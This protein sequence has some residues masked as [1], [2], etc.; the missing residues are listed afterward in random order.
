MHVLNPNLTLHLVHP[1][2]TSENGSSVLGRLVRKPI[3]SPL[4]GL[5]SAHIFASPQYCVDMIVEV[6]D[7]TPA[8]IGFCPGLIV[9]THRTTGNTLRFHCEECSLMKRIN[10]S[11]NGCELH[12]VERVNYM[13]FR[14]C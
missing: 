13:K 6:E 9:W 1:K 7:S 5:D 11:V 10:I 14:Q 2:G 3:V 12:T 8:V 4:G